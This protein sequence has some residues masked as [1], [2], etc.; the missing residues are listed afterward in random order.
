MKLP[1]IQ[2][3]APVLLLVATAVGSWLA[4]KIAAAADHA[5]ALDRAQLLSHIATDCAALVASL[6]PG[7]PWA[8]LL[9]ETVKAITRAAGVPTQNVV[10]I[11]NAAAGALMRLGKSPQ[12]NP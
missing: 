10:A 12:A 5:K 9:E 4:S 6:F 3:L 8:T 1:L 11:Q 7:K 2:S